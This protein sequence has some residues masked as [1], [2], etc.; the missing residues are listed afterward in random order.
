LD[1]AELV[2]RARKVR[3]RAMAGLAVTDSALAFVKRR[4]CLFVAG[5]G[6]F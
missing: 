1:W 2:W 4:G 5:V 6:V 3:R